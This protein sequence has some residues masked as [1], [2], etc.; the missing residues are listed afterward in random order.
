MYQEQEAV[1]EFVEWMKDL[2]DG[3]ALFSNIMEGETIMDKCVNI[4][5]EERK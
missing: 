2:S 3:G 1:K 4:K 5:S